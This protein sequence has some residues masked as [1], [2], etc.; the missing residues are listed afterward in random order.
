MSNITSLTIWEKHN[1][2]IF[3]DFGTA[4]TPDWVKL[5]KS[6]VFDLAM[7]PETE[8]FDFIEDETP[9][10]I[11]KHYKPSMAQEVL[12]GEGDDAFD[13]LFA[14]YHKRPVGA[15]AVVPV[16]IVYP[17]AGTGEGTFVAMRGEAMIAFNNFNTVD[18]KLSFDMNFSG[19]EN[20]TATFT[21]GSP[22]FT[23]DA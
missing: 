3:L 22:T 7:N 16:M 20:G 17:K 2:R 18:R 1:T 9:T 19:L 13:A 11:L 5:G 4:D 14:M 6:T 10:D 12:M 21:S 8:T 23:A 15:D